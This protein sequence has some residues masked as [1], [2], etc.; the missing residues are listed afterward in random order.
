MCYVNV[1]DKTKVLTANDDTY[2]HKLEKKLEQL[3]QI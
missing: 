1:I 2:T 3:V